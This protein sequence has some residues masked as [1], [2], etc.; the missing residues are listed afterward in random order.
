VTATAQAPPGYGTAGAAPAEGR[1]KRD[2]WITYWIFA[3]FYLV[4]SV[5]ICLLGRATPPPRPDVSDL[6]AANWFAQHHLGIQIGFVILLMIAGCAAIVN[7]IIG[8]FMM[9]MTSGK[10]FA[11][12]CIGS[13]GVGAV[14]GL[15]P[16]PPRT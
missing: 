12:A 9:R 6:Q 14:P 15:S 10:P 2:L 7:G 16:K 4:L 8:Y 5:C 1:S 11:Y 3:V 13:M